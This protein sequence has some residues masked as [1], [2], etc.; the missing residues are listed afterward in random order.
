MNTIISN[1][2]KD[3]LNNIA[4]GVTLGSNRTSQY[5][6]KLMSMLNSS[7]THHHHTNASSLMEFNEHSV[8]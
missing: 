7:L 8:D 5:M 2:D 4:N 3:L 6:N 1:V